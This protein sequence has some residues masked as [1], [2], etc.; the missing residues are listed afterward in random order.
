MNSR[1]SRIYRFGDFTL[2]SAERQLRRN[3]QV[4]FLRP[5][6]FETLLCLVER[7]GHLI[8]K[9]DLM[10]KVWPDTSVSEAVLSHCVAEI[11]QALEDDP[12]KPRFIATVPRLGYKFLA[13]TEEIDSESKDEKHNALSAAPESAIVVLPFKNIS[14]DPENEH[15]CDGLSEEL[16]NGLTK[17]AN[18]RV[19]AHSSAFVFKG[20]DTDVR[21]IGQK[22]NV[23]SVLE[24]SVR[25]IGDWLRISV[26]LIDARNGYHVWSEQYDR[27]MEDVFVI[28]DEI[29]QS[30]LEK[31]KISGTR[32]AH[33]EL[34]RTPTTSMEAYGLY[35]KGRSFWHRRYKGFLQ[36]A[37]ECF[38]ETIEKDP[39]YSLA[40]VGLADCYLS[41]GVW[42]MADP[43]V[44]LPK[45]KVMADRALQIDQE[46]AEAHASRAVISLAYDWDW[47]AAERG[48]KRSLA[49]NP[50]CAMTHLWY[51]H[52]LAILGLLKEAVEE[53]R[54]AQRL[55]PL[56]PVIST[57][58]GYT[59]FL[60]GDCESA[61]LE[62]RKTLDL[63]PYFGTAYLHLG[64]I[65]AYQGNY[66]DAMEAYRKCLEMTGGLLRQAAGGLGYASALA[67]D[68][69][70]AKAILREFDEKQAYIP[71]LARAVIYIGMRD[72][73]NTYE[74]L[75]K[76]YEGRDF[77]LA[78]M[79]VL[80]IFNR[81]RSQPQFQKLLARMHLA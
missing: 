12:G 34:A 44:L 4:I 59:L 70:K 15:F 16:I 65:L 41:L 35:L 9:N 38:E 50:G 19:V 42:G 74:W 27:K 46:L 76:A 73:G 37:I 10:D 79:K 68:L 26:Q 39:A 7:Q 6:A 22:L 21:E 69:R 57:M 33:A 54:Q 55:D 81:L 58:A 62:I 48:L 64:I 77:T 1:V 67:G 52:Y 63:D 45:A 51:S 71:P 8:R 17:N 32:E 78:W 47:P 20:R 23:G 36:K 28:Q 56:S 3:V 14:A 2:D 72:D 49:L 61:L 30:V 40:Y 5:K 43:H 18:L 80:P 24:G 31:L 53:A 25:K 75:N 13:K 11:R 60:A 66:S 29:A